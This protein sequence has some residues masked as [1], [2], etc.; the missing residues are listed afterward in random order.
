MAR[1]NNNP[2]SDSDGS[3]HV[4]PDEEEFFNDED[5]WLCSAR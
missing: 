3:F 2:D 4:N 1:Q 5:H